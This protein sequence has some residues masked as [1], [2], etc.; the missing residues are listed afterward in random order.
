MSK[1]DYVM[2]VLITVPVPENLASQNVGADKAEV[3]YTIPTSSVEIE[4]V[5]VELE[6]TATGIK[7]TVV[8]P[9]T[10]TSIPLDNLTPGTT[11]RT[12]TRSLSKDGRASEFS[13]PV[14][15]TTCKKFYL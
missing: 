7:T 9:A 5:E 4:N 13:A 2:F 10:S 11:Y 12:R 1:N 8:R 15:F 6:N 14:E 3:T